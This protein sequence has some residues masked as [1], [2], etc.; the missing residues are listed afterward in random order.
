MT[1]QDFFI[2]SAPDEFKALATEIV[3]ATPDDTTAAI[4]TYPR[5]SNEC[6]Y[7]RINGLREDVL[8]EVAY[9]VAHDVC[10]PGHEHRLDQ[11]EWYED[12]GNGH[13]AVTLSKC[14]A[15]DRK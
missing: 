3:A 12:L 1:N 8:A 10:A 13:I 5:S 11:L 7:E 6:S 2:Q 15:V 4:R 9:I 14:Y